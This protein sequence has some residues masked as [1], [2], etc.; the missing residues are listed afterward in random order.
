MTQTIH[1]GKRNIAIHHFTGK[2]ASSSKNME[3][4]VHG[5]G[6][7]GYSYQGT[8]GSAPVRI[9]STTVIHDQL[10]LID[11]TGTE[12]ALQ[13]KD[14]DLACRE[15]NIVSAVWGIVEGDNS[16]PY[17]AILNHTTHTEFVKD[18]KIREL[19]I[20]SI[21][22]FKIKSVAIGCAGFLAI[23]VLLGLIWW[24]LSI[25]FIVYCIYYEFAV[26]RPKIK[27]FNATLKYPNPE[28]W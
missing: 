24:P 25:A 27:E 2:V 4:K 11:K 22:P 9:S 1:L 18:K 5:G 6:G 8:G 3:T 28:L 19:V 12:K 17:F 14:F 23:I 26:V 10:F 7:G 13:L 16:G 21:A 15:S 20:A